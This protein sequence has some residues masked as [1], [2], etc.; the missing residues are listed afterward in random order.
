[1][2]IIIS[3]PEIKKQRWR[4]FTYVPRVPQLSISRA[5]V[6]PGQTQPPVRGAA[7]APCQGDALW[8]ARLGAGAAPR[9]PPH[10]PSETTTA[11]GVT[12]LM[13]SM[14]GPE[15]AHSPQSWDPSNTVLSNPV[16]TS[17][18]WPLSTWRVTSQ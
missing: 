3:S 14:V 6:Q 17:H 7:P 16:A 15:P 1:M 13:L 2:G 18:V 5:T 8:G 12:Q 10:L 4:E 11:Q 9:H